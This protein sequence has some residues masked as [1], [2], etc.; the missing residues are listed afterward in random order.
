MSASLFYYV[1]MRTD[2]YFCSKV[3]LLC[4]YSVDHI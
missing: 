2:L 1:N 4:C 3:L